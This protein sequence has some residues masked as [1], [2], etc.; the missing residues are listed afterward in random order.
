MRSDTCMEP[1]RAREIPGTAADDAPLAIDAWREARFE[2][3][4]RAGSVRIFA[5]RFKVLQLQGHYLDMPA[6]PD[7]LRPPLS[8]L[9]EKVEALVARSQPIREPLPRLALVDGALRFVVAQYSR[10]HADLTG[11]FDGYLSKFA[12][13]TRNTLKRK[14]RK[15]LDRGSGSYMREYRR[16]E[17][18]ADFYRRARSVSALTYQERL[19]DAGLP[20]EPA[21]LDELVR[22]ARADAVRAYLLFQ[23]DEAIAYL[24]CPIV[25]GVLLYDYLGYDPKH[26]DL[27]PGTVL[28]YLAFQSLFAE[29]KFR[30]FDFTEGDGAHKRLFGTHETL[31]AD[32]CFFPATTGVRFWL[33]LHMGLE[34]LSEKA[35]A[36]LERL[37]LKA[38]L[39]K[40]VRRG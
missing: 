19:L 6:D 40:L 3:V 13:K 26:A 10:H 21:Y 14:V 5:R 27:S 39:K 32:I 29:G 23:N 35:V 20:D 15:F 16:P 28:Q 34:R 11:S 25:N 31:C 24:C 36:I 9:G 30:A 12:A 1:D 33:G 22:L 38:G 17:E 7:Q 37:G 4:Y 2:L 8:R 18:L